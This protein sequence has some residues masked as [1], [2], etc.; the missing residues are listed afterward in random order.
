MGNLIRIARMAWRYRTRLSIAYITFFFGIG[1][2]LLIPWLFGES[3]DALVLFEDGQLIPQNPAITTLLLLALALLGASLCRG[4]FDF[5]RTY[6]TDSLSQLV[7]FD[8]RNYIYDKLQH[9]SF[10][11]HDKEHTGNLMSKATADVEAVRRWINMGL[12]RSLE[13]AVRVTAITVILAFLNWELALL[14]LVFVPFLV[15]RSTLVMAKLRRMWLHVQEVNGELV[16]VLQENL[17]GIHVVKAF[18]SE[19]HEKRKYRDKAIELREEYY[20]SERL[21]GVNSAWMS[22]Y[23]TFALGLILW[24]GGWE[25]LR[26]DLTPGEL[27][28]FVLFLNQLTFPIRQAA[29]IINSFS[30]A[31]S[32]GERIFDVLDAESPVLEKPN[33]KVMSRSQGHVLFND[34]SFSYDEKIPALKDVEIDAPPGSI[35]AILGAPGSGKSTIVN[36]LPRFYDITSGNITIDS[37]D[38]RDFTLESLRRN[39]GIVQQDVYLFSATI[40]DNIAYGAVDATHEDVVEAAKIAQLHEHIISLPDGYD[41][42]VGERGATLSGGQRQRLSIART[43][44]INPP[45]LILDDST[46]SVDVETERLIH[47]AMVAVVKGRTTFV[48]AHRL[49]TVRAADQIL[50]LQDGS[51]SQRGNHQKLILEDGSYKDIYE[52]QLR[53][54]EEIMLDAAIPA[55]SPRNVETEGAN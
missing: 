19:E 2:S 50:V 17:V 47:Q 44:L 26:G 41:T 22:L 52:M 16:T 53:P 33:A 35:T 43:I 23:F 1:A 6:T 29:Q 40:R 45:V 18:A 51:V 48:I 28:K 32:S 7:S 30:R 42:W 13:V 46:S 36:L 25:V 15:L 39:V 49:S 20:Q 55:S 14:S 4:F 37:Q 24:Y 9:V 8:F 11:Y 3:I 31:A 38:I 10:A 34:V 21:Q 12:V 54:Q 27:T 5:G